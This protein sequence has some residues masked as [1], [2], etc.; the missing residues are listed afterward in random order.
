[1]I[2]AR[3]TTAVPALPNHYPRGDIGD[4]DGVGYRRARTERGGKHCGNGVTGPR[5]IVYLARQSRKSDRS[6]RRRAP[7]SYPQPRE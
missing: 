6:G 7:T 1:M 5:D 3:S 4:F 2:P